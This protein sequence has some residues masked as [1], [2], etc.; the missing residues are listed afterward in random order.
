[1]SNNNEVPLIM[2]SVL[3][4][5]DGG[6]TFQSGFS[7]LLGDAMSDEERDQIN[8]AMDKLIDLVE[9][10]FDRVSDEAFDPENF[11]AEDEDDEGENE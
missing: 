11:L 3:A 5:D 6:L 7:K 1:M 4:E 10:I 2:L 8:S 9:P